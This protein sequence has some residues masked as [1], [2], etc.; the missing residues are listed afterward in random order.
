MEYEMNTRCK[1]WKYMLYITTVAT[2]F[3]S[4]PVSTQAANVKVAITG[5]TNT[6]LDITSSKTD[7]AANTMRTLTTAGVA[8]ILDADISMEKEE[9]VALVKSKTVQSTDKKKESTLVMANVNEYVS[10]RKEPDLDSEKLGILYKDCSGQLIE[11]GDEW[12]EITSGG[13]TGWVRN[14]YL[15]FGDEAQ[16][17]AEEVG[18]LTARSNTETL[19]V[20]KEASLDSGILGLLAKGEAVEAIEEDGDWV[21]VSYEG[22]TG[23][24]A[25]EYVTVE[26]TVDEAESMEVIREREAEEKARE[27]AVVNTV[28]TSSDSSIQPTVMV[29]KEAV[30]ATASELEIL[31]AL[32]Q[33]EAGGEPYEG[34]VAVGAVVMNRVRCAAYPDTITDVIYASGQFVPASG[35]RMQ[36]LILNGTTKESCIQA[37]QEAINGA[38][39]VGDALYFRRVGSKSGTIIGN[40]VFW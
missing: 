11:K 20:R 26:F 5:S 34:Q 21:S 13:I 35:S 40:H 29:Q 12:S 17:V 1:K 39:P 36:N 15:Y 14:K 25:A 19:R 28:A 33:C 38:S 24:V 3:A 10:I 23:Y 37:A 27:A 32:I 4:T 31:A 8:D 30:M 6:K 18:I 7:S 9:L 22:T 2:A 16:K